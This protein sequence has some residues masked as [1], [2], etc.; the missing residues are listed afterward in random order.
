METG[1][2]PST[3]DLASAEDAEDAELTDGAAGWAWPMVKS[4]STGTAPSPSPSDVL[5]C[6]VVARGRAL[7]RIILGAWREIRFVDIFH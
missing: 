4:L 1:G 3:V 7:K 2:H 5:D 6:S